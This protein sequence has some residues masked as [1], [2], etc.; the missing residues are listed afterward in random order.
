M[1]IYCQSND[2]WNYN[3]R[4]PNFLVWGEFF[5]LFRWM[6]MAMGALTLRSF[7]QWCRTRYIA[8][9]D[10]YQ[11]DF[12]L[13]EKSCFVGQ[14]L[15]CGTNV[16]LWD[17][18]L[19]C[20]KLCYSQFMVWQKLNFSGERKWGAW[21]HSGGVQSLWSGWRRVFS[22]LKFDKKRYMGSFFPKLNYHFNSNVV[23]QIHHMWGVEPCNVHLGRASLKVWFIF[24]WP[25][26]NM[27]IN[28]NND[29]ANNR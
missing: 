14:M 9:F 8:P 29:D 28:H 2:Q 12:N 5:E 7:S 11:T 3:Y 26:S 22:C 27:I 20:G 13:W 19:F 18:M 23:V 24:F 4:L 25:L 10:S 16:I 1:P 17:D 15:F 21:G 6:K